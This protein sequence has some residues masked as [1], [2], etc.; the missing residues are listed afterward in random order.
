MKDPHPIQLKILKK[1]LF[2]KSL[3][4]TDLKPDNEIESNQLTFHLEQ[5]I[6][7]D[8]VIKQDS[9]YFLTDL[10]KEFANRM[11]TE[12]VTMIKQAKVSVFVAPIKKTTSGNQ[13]LIYT[14]LKQPFYGCQGFL[15]GK[16]PFGET[17]IEA[18]RRE[19][20]EETGLLGKPVLTSVRHYLV[21]DK[22]N[23][24]LLEDKFMFMC[25]VKN[26]KGK[27][28]PSG[29]GKYEWVKEED[30]FSYV[31]NHFVG[32]DQFKEDIDIIKNFSGQ[33]NFKEIIQRTNSF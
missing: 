27:L 30:L 15:S 26:P 33:V 32:M 23:K 6:K 7:A 20:E 21:F 12:N 4:F 28:I 24:N 3:K 5:I 10:G 19:F 14:R 25:V 18:A 1:L 11:D 2:A 22:N 16:V 8:F 31:T 13:Y 17:V 9:Q 29:E